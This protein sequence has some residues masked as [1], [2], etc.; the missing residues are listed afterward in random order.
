MINR[1]QKHFHIIDFEDVG[2]TDSRFDQSKK[3]DTAFV[4]KQEST[5]EKTTLTQTPLA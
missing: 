2:I 4:A 3:F 1:L 5:K